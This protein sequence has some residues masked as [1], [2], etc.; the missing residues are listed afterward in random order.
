[1]GSVEGVTRG[2]IKWALLAPV[3]AALLVSGGTW[4]YI[5]FIHSDAPPPLTVDTSVATTAPRTSTSVASTDSTT[6]QAASGV[7]GTWKIATGTQVGYR[8]KEVL[9]GQS[10]TAVGRT[11]DVTGQMV[12]DGAA[13]QS[14]TFTANMATVTSNESR[15]DNQ[16]NGRVMN[17][18]TYPTSTFALTSPIDFSSIPADGTSIT[19]KATGD[20]TLR[21]V[22]KRVT[23]DLTATRA[24][25]TI[26]VAGSVPITFADW[27]IP[28]PSGGP[29]TTENHGTIE[30]LLVFSR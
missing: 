6:A 5:H 13:V 29:A 27:N 3:T 17:T 4:T 12:I 19:E 20:L 2:W 23:V 30:F 25:A 11:S 16:Y 18:S 22:K 15:R 26:K 28:N 8:V 9:F 21:G 7:A 14:A 24:G 10:A 1:M